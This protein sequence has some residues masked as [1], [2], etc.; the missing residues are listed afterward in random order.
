[1]VAA[2]P[3]DKFQRTTVTLRRGWAFGSASGLPLDPIPAIRVC[4]RKIITASVVVAGFL[5]ATARAAGPSSGIAGIDQVWPPSPEDKVVRISGVYPHL[6]VYNNSGE[7]GIGALAPWAGKLWFVTYPPHAPQGST[8]KLYALDPSLKLEIRPESVGGTHA[9]RMIHPESKQLIIGPYF[10]DEQGRVRTADIKQLV[11]RITANARHLTDPTNKVYFV[12]MERELYEVDVHTLEVK[13]I[14]G[15]NG[16]PFPGTHGK[17]AM[18]SE[19]RLIVA[20]NGESGFSYV[21]DLQL[22]GPAG[23]LAESDG[24]DWMQKWK[25]IERTPFTE[26]TGPGGLQGFAPGDNRVWALG[27]DKRSVILE[28]RENGRWHTFRLPKGSFTHDALHGWYTEWPRIREVTDGRLLAHMHGLFYN[29]PRSFSMADHGGLR[30][31]STY[32]RMPVDY[33]AWQGQIVMARDDSSIMQNEM[34]GQSCSGLWFGSWS[35]LE[36]FGAPVGWGGPWLDDEVRAGDVSAPFLVSGF[37]EG[38]LHLKHGADHAVTFAV[39]TDREGRNQWQPAFRVTVPGKGYAWQV[40][41]KELACQWMRVKAE[42]AAPG[43]SAFFRLGNPARPADPGR[44]AAL[45]D[46]AYQGPVVDGLV[47]PAAGDAR[48]LLMAANTYQGAGVTDKSGWIMDGALEFKPMPDPSRENVLRERYGTKEG[49]TVDAAS[50]I[51]GE[52][53]KRFR[54][55]KTSPA[56]E[57]PFASGWPRA[58]R[59]VV[60][61]RNLLNADGTIYEVPRADLGGFQRMRPLTTHQKRISDFASWRGLLVLAGVRADAGTDEHCYKS[62]DGRAAV[63]FGNVDDLWSMGPPVGVGGPWKDT[64]VEANV[65]SDPYLMAGYRTK[66]LE[67]SH[68]SAEPV[69]FTV[70][71]DFAANGEWSEYTKLTVQPGKTVVHKF[72]AGYS[73]HWVRLQADR[74]TKASAILTYSP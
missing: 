15:L 5:A 2:T 56:Y 19:G 57:K 21:N 27:W 37:T 34:A 53:G 66:S 6:A 68:R 13:K 59:E 51:V 39:E 3:P 67:L 70:E 17:G 32:T 61:E 60:T 71:V 24:K 40:L 7:C 74:A 72:P 30:A 73:T 1:M 44:F 20:N 36:N 18:S 23:C 22:N 46:I 42:E 12:G 29:F 16:G 63:W 52:R 41:S 4:V 54:L 47:K 10:I 55:P 14:Y 28:L 62:A 35:D 25:V 8:D 31:I 45:A 33:C 9:N 11:L 43:V 26:V 64:E 65:P 58:L 50:V 49:L 38:V 48:K 69:A